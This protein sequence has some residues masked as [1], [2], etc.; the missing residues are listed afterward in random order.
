LVVART[1]SVSPHTRLAG[2]FFPVDQ[3]FVG[4]KLSKIYA[5]GQ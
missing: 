4:F 1:N 3:H 5:V 2:E